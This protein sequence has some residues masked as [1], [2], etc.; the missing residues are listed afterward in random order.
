MNVK[1]FVCSCWIEGTAHLIVIHHSEGV[2]VSGY[3]MITVLAHIWGRAK[4]TDFKFDRIFTYTEFTWLTHVSD[5]LLLVFIH[6]RPVADQHKVSLV[7]ARAAEEVHKIWPILQT[8]MT[9]HV[10]EEKLSKIFIYLYT[11][12]KQPKQTQVHAIKWIVLERVKCLMQGQ[13]DFQLWL[14]NNN[15]RCMCLYIL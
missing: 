2:L 9:L 5:N 6:H 3:D 11:Q 13:L 10:R 15:Q 1:L 4:V 8:G 14:E 12:H 7:T